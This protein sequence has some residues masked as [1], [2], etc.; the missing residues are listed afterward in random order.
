LPQRKA[1]SVSQNLPGKLS[2]I[3]EVTVNLEESPWHLSRLNE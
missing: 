3:I 1:W 2:G